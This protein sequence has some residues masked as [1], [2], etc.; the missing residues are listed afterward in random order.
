[1]PAQ[2]GAAAVPRAS[3]LWGTAD[4]VGLEVTSGAGPRVNAVR[5]RV[6]G[7]S[8]LPLIRGIRKMQ[9]GWVQKVHGGHVGF[10]PLGN[11]AE[12]MFCGVLW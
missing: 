8:L 5:T 1:M 9:V 6:F 7:S 3:W 10:V 11:L 2:P 12:E 4:P